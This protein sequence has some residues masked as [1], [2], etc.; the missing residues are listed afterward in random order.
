[1]IDVTTGLLRIIGWTSFCLGL[2]ISCLIG[3][4]M[5]A[6]GGGLV[7]ALEDTFCSRLIFCF[8]LGLEG[9][10]MLEKEGSIM[11]A[12]SNNWSPLLFDLEK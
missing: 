9:E 10:D 7:S 4:T 6:S 8:R 2:G 3:K 11:A 5:A 1:M 12:L